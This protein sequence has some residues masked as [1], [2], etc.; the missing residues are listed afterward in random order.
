MTR[1]LV[2]RQPYVRRVELSTRRSA[3]EEVSMSGGGRKSTR[4]KQKGSQSDRRLHVVSTQRPSSCR[5]NRDG[6][7][8]PI[9]TRK[10]AILRDPKFGSLH[11]FP[12]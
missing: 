10:I 11:D 6:K 8:H 7:R 12:T 4:G 3:D 1:V 2:S 5:V 9:V